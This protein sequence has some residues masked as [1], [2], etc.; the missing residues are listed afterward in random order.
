MARRVE[1]FGDDR[2]RDCSNE[3]SV[4][5]RSSERSSLSSSGISAPLGNRAAAQALPAHIIEEG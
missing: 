2:E 3:C 1:S 4:T 5:K